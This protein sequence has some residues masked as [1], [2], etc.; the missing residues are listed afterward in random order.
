[1]CANVDMEDFIT[2]HHEL[3]HIQYDIQYK[4]LPITLREGAN[5]GNKPSVT[6]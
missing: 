1:M 2:I 5:P 6:L 3:G 4:D